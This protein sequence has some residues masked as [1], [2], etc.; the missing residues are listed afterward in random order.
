MVSL[1]PSYRH[2]SDSINNAPQ[3][4][5]SDDAS[6]G[7]SRSSNAVRLD[8]CSPINLAEPSVCVPVSD[9]VTVIRLPGSR[10]SH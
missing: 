3:Y 6:T 9:R 7:S 5:I 1:L 10:S 8:C 4:G 2:Y